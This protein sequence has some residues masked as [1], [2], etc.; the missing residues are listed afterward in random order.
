M[1]KLGRPK[2]PEDL[3]KAMREVR[4]LRAEIAKAE[5]KPQRD[6]QPIEI[7][8]NSPTSSHEPT[9]DEN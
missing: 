4:R 8:T 3:A 2:T 9:P 6:S 7:T 1:A 5:A